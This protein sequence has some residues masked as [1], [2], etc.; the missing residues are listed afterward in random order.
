MH[1]VIERGE[2]IDNQNVKNPW[3]WPWC[4][5]V[6]VLSIK[7]K[8]PSTTWNGKDTIT[9]MVGSTFREVLRLHIMA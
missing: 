7:E 4:E 8:L 5:K 2:K 6:K 9:L 1:R 3:N